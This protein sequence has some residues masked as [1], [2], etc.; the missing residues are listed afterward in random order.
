MFVGA[1]ASALIALWDGN[2]ATIP[3]WNSV[4][5]AFSGMVALFFAK[6]GDK[7]GLVVRRKWGEKR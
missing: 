5:L 2:D 3:D 1:L 4:Y 6:D 7:S